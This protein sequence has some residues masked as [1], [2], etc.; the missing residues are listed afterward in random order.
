MR[1]FRCAALC[2]VFTVLLSS[3]ALQD[4]GAGRLSSK[5]FSNFLLEGDYTLM[6]GDEAVTGSARVNKGKT[7]RIDILSPDPYGGIAVESDASGAPSILS[8]SYSGINVELTP[9][10]FSKLNLAFGLFTPA[11]CR[12]I[13]KMSREKTD[14]VKESYTLVGLTDIQPVSITTKN[15]GNTVTYIYDKTTGTPLAMNVTAG[16]MSLACK[17]TKIKFE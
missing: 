17:V 4:N 12:K 10:A 9:E 1:F 11:T 15:E 5:L 3:C 6:V 8:F 2:L 7:T 13:E 16:D 14:E